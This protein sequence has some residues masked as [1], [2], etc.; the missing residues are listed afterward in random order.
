MNQATKGAVPEVRGMARRLVVLGTLASAVATLPSLATTTVTTITYDA[1][2]HV[3]SVTDPRG[4]K[5]TYTLDG[6]G[7]LRQ[8]RCSTSPTT[9]AR[10][11]SAG[12]AR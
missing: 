10:T 8:Q 12:C 4:L 9:A 5:T 6:L 1:G 7:R 2:N 11:V 3:T